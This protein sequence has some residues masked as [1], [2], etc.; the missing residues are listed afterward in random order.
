MLV[1]LMDG[2]DERGDAATGTAV[3]IEGGGITLCCPVD[4]AA[5][6][7]AVG[8]DETGVYF[9]VALLAESIPPNPISTAVA[10]LIPLCSCD[11]GIKSRGIAIV[12]SSLKSGGT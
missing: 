11:F 6:G 10:T 1:P 3:G 2:C 5:G 4:V 9:P 7:G 12:A 8:T